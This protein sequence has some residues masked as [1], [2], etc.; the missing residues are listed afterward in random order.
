[1]GLKGAYYS[2]LAKVNCIGTAFKG[3]Y[4]KFKDSNVSIQV[5]LRCVELN[6]DIIS[7]EITIPAVINKSSSGIAGV[8]DRSDTLERSNL[9]TDRKTGADALERSDPC[10]SAKQRGRDGR[11]ATPYLPRPK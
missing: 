5:R 8:K 6:T 3:L 2:K 7:N 11:A 10:L 1:M 4:N 9:T